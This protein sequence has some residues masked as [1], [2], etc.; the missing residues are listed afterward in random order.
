MSNI[1]NTFRQVTSTSPY[2][3]STNS[4]QVKN[5]VDV[6]MN[7]VS[8]SS[9]S[10]GVSSLTSSDNE[11][12]NQAM[13]I[14]GYFVSLT[15]R[16]IYTI[17]VSGDEINPIKSIESQVGIPYDF[18]LAQAAN[19]KFQRV[20]QDNVVKNRYIDLLN[21]SDLDVSYNVIRSQIDMPDYSKYGKVWGEEAFAQK[22]N[23]TFNLYSSNQID[24]DG[25]KYPIYNKK[26][27]LAK[28]ENIYNKGFFT[29][30][31]WQNPTFRKTAQLAKV[32]LKEDRMDAYEAITSRGEYSTDCVEVEIYQMPDNFGF[33]TQQ[34]F[35]D[36]SPRGSQTPL[37]FYDKNQPRILDMTLKLH[38]QEYPLEP[39]LSI[40]EKLQYLARPYRH[41]DFSLIPKLVRV[42][43]PGRVFRG[44][45]S[46]ISINYSGDDYTGWE[47]PERVYEGLHKKNGN[48]DIYASTGELNYPNIEA[49]AKAWE[50]GELKGFS[51]DKETMY[52]GLSSISATI[53]LAIVEEIKLSL[54]T[55][56]IE[57]QEEERKA[58]EEEEKRKREEAIENARNNV[59]N[60][61]LST[62]PDELKD[63]LVD[64][65]IYVDE[66]GYPV[67]YIPFTPINASFDE[68]V[69]AE[70]KKWA[71]E[72]QGYKSLEDYNNDKEVEQKNQNKSSDVSYA[73]EQ[74]ARYLDVNSNIEGRDTLIDVIMSL[75]QQ[76]GID[77]PDH[78]TYEENTNKEFLITQTSDNLNERRKALLLLL[79]DENNENGKSQVRFF[80]EESTDT[81]RNSMCKGGD[82]YLLGQLLA[83]SIKDASSVSEYCN[84]V[85]SKSISFM[86][87]EW[88]QDPSSVFLISMTEGRDY[89]EEPDFVK[90]PLATYKRGFYVA[91]SENISNLY[92]IKVDKTLGWT[93]VYITIS[94]MD[95]DNKYKSYIK[96]VVDDD[97]Y[98]LDFP[99][100]KKKFKDLLVY[101]N[102]VGHP[103]SDDKTLFNYFV[104]LYQDI[105]NDNKTVF[106]SMINDVCGNNLFPREQ[107]CSEH[108]NI[109]PRYYIEPCK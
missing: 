12:L 99:T 1:V 18:L 57:K 36:A 67:D 100:D 98:P 62:F 109:E 6:Q 90:L 80:Y 46:S 75:Q 96:N 93:K 79:V 107:D 9:L 88:G 91:I 19:E 43:I 106:N 65:L 49:Q 42:S 95:L 76:V 25:K 86:K 59:K 85:V 108:E 22:I 71:L 13:K 23:K 81:F 41:S 16:P 83:F 87:Q 10:Y 54:Y 11:V 82:H 63:E 50:R 68:K 29:N 20:F 2:E 101:H 55:T 60:L 104:K 39:L 34:Q 44:Y 72:R 15:E 66:N 94:D 48:T 58:Q 5:I 30:L 37:R 102:E 53:N 52:Y 74:F 38:Q 77:K 17:P 78:Q 26:I 7:G 32:I 33:G 45:I 3:E 70:T 40:A 8:P 4:Q 31:G 14:I 47:S 89:T 73:N 69:L 56:F 21:V 84:L 97:E 103:I 92:K 28:I 61:E 27:R 51:N 105:L 64:K 24:K 35:S